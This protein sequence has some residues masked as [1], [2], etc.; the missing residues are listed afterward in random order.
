V[1]T[2]AAVR[3]QNR[4]RILREIFREGSISRV[5]LV[6]A[7]GLT[8]TAITRITRELIDVGLVEESDQQTRKEAPG[9]RETGL[10]IS[11]RVA[12]VIAV[13]LHIDDRSIVLADIRGNIKDC[14]DLDIPFSENQSNVIEQVAALA[15]KLV[16][17]N[18]LSLNQILGLAISVAGKIDPLKGVLVESRVY[19]WKDVPIREILQ[20]RTGLPIAIENLNNSINLSETRFGIARGLRNVLLV[21][22]GTGL[23]GAS[24]IIDGHLL[25]GHQSGAGLIHHLPLNASKR[26]CECGR[27]GCLNTIASGLG[28]LACY[29]QTEPVTLESGDSPASNARIIDL[30][31]IAEE[32]DMVARAILREGG[33]SLCDALLP[34]V[35]TLCPEVILVAGK[36]GR[37]TH[38]FGGLLERWGQKSN[39]DQRSSVKLLPTQKSVLEATIDLCIDSFL[40]SADLDLEQLRL[41]HDSGKAA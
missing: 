11:N 14:V 27:R 29:E 41:L 13:S 24:M 33:E 35:E 8:G 7:T 38:Y 31:Q 6:S 20:Q 16:E 30:L 19:G 26:L 28:V 22:V 40:L 37:S 5:G 17:R 21:R 36:V 15:L 32:G 23:L 2:T 1:Q 18:K 10:F 9:R 3:Q 12:H 25:R 39:L 34:I 4:K